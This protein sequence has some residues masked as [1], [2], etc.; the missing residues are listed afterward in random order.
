MGLLVCGFV[1]LFVGLF[2]GFWVGWFGGI[3]EQ[4]QLLIVFGIIGEK[5][6]FV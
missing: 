3:L 1:G 2:D 4:T 6:C 5:D